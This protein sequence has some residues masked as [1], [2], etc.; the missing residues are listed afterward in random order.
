MITYPNHIMYNPFDKFTEA[1]VKK[2]IT[3]IFIF[4]LIFFGG[5]FLMVNYISADV[6]RSS[7]YPDNEVTRLLTE[8]D[9][10]YNEQDL[11][12]LRALTPLEPNGLDNPLNWEKLAKVESIMISDN[13]SLKFQEPIFGGQSV[14]G[15]A[16]LAMIYSTVVYPEETELWINETMITFDSFISQ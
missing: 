11:D 2:P 9:D 6:S 5:I 15:P 12:L 7:F 13:S 3:A 14:A 4:I 1:S 8:I 16:S 10:E